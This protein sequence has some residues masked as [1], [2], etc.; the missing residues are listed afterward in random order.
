M[1]RIA[2]ASPRSTRRASGNGFT[3]LELLVV[4]VILGLLASYVG[5]RYFGQIGRSEVQVARAQMDAFGKAL[6]QYRLDVGQYP[7]TEQGLVALVKA[8]ANTPRWMGPYLKKDPPLDPWGR[9]YIYRTSPATG[10][11]ELMSLGKDGRPGGEGENVDV[12]H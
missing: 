4:L 5:P 8:P 9:P 3:L 7:T 1:C 6:D 12:K 10:E 2:S 11:Y